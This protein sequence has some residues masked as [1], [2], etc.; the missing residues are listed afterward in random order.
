MTSSG[1]TPTAKEDV[2]AAG[3]PQA[4]RDRPKSRGQRTEA[5]LSS[6]QLGSSP[7]GQS[8]EAGSSAQQAEPPPRGRW[9]HFQ[10]IARMKSSVAKEAYALARNGQFEEFVKFMKDRGVSDERI[11]AAYQ[12]ATRREATAPAKAPPARV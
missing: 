2:S 12:V 1:V 5:G 10:S 4:R 9:N 7:R 3:P 6:R 11:I 8:V